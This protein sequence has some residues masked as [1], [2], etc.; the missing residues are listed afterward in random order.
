MSG[1][2]YLIGGGELRDGE[3]RLIDEDIL[4]LKPVGS[5]FVFFGF[6]AQDST[7]Y[8]NTIKSVYG[9]KYSVV[10]PTVAKGREY[11]I[12]AIK[13]AAIIYLG[14][15][16]TDQLLRVFAEW[17]LVEHLR[18]AIDRGV[19]IAGMSA[20]AQALS[21]QFVQEDNDSIELRKGWGI[22]PVDILVHANPTSFGKAKLLW[23]RHA[24]TYQF[25]AIGEG[26]AWRVDT[27]KSTEIGAGKIWTIS[28]QK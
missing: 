20:G 13:S 18:A 5:T 3:T 11:A 16:N 24:M 22:V 15:G 27:L 7:D 2:I 14:G 23:S 6:A 17:G 9:D 28:T 26:A 25:I 21:T 1:V 8:A 19:H 4:S 12:N 10:V